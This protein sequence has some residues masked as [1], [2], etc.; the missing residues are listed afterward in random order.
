[1]DMMRLTINSNTV[2]A[3]T[4][5]IVA[6]IIMITIVVMLKDKRKEKKEIHDLL[7]DLRKD[8]KEKEVMEELDK[9]IK[10][11]EKVQQI[12]SPP[13][14][15]IEKEIVEEI[16]EETPIKDTTESVSAPVE[17]VPK[18][19][20]RPNLEELNQKEEI[21]QFETKKTEIEDMLE[22]MQ[23][24]LNKQ[25]EEIVNDFEHEQEEKSIISYQ[26]LVESIQS[27]SPKV[28]VVDDELQYRQDQPLQAQL[29]ETIEKIEHNQSE[30]SI[31]KA[32]AIEE[33]IKKF[34]STEFISP[35]Y[36]KMESHLDYPTVPSFEKEENIDEDDL[37]WKN[38]SI[39]HYL[40][41]FD[42][43]NNME[44]NTL[45]QTLNMPPISKE[46]KKNDEFLQALKEFRRNLD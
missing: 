37:D 24:D 25:P 22:K 41:E 18:V 35:V 20:N 23:E 1:M 19:E 44:I 26:E 16:K 29:H 11:E 8:R 42:F 2:L 45:E 13:S 30:S 36:G 7:T 39:D 3:I 14:S 43:K 9:E 38:R 6:I 15:D 27:K 32:P 28:E 40:E 5:A 46:T 4:F 17:E 21:P 34:K 10:K 33:A 31:S 12:D